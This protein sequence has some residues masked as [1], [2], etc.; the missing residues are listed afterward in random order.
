M[1]EHFMPYAIRSARKIMA[2]ALRDEGTRIVYKAN[3]AMKIYDYQ[4]DLTGKRNLNVENCNKIA[5]EVL[6]LVFEK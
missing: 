6:K 3:V 1:R 4:K 2:Y 5:D